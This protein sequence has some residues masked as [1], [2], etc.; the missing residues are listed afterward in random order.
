[1]CGGFELHADHG[2]VRVG[3]DVEVLVVPVNLDLVRAFIIARHD[4]RGVLW[5][6]G[7][8]EQ[9]SQVSSEVARSRG[10]Q[11][12]AAESALARYRRTV[13]VRRARNT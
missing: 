11:G 2:R 8:R 5:H 9:N 7:R 10:G 6:G 4:G 3:R 1:M 12:N 13:R